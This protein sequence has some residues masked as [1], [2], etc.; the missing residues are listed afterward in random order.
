MGAL[1]GMLRLV[2]AAVVATTMFAAPT[3]AAPARVDTV[4][5]LTIALESLRAGDDAGYEAAADE[6]RSDGHWLPSAGWDALEQRDD[7]QLS[8]V[9]LL[10]DAPGDEPLLFA[11]DQVVVERELNAAPSAGAADL[12]FLRLVDADGAMI[13]EVLDHRGIGISPEART[14]LEPLPSDLTL[15]PAPELY[16]QVVAMMAN[17]IES[18]GYPLPPVPGLEEL[19]ASFPVDQLPPPP[20][21]GPRPLPEPPTAADPPAIET[22]SAEPAAP[23]LA[24]ADNDNDAGTDIDAGSTTETDTGPVTG[25]EAGPGGEGVAIDEAT[26]GDAAIVTEPSIPDAADPGGASNNDVEPLTLVIGAVGA[27]GLALAVVAMRRNRHNHQLADIAYTDS[28]TGLGNRR[29]LDLDLSDEVRHG[30]RPTSVLMIDVD[31]FKRFNDRHGHVAGDDVLRRVATVIARNVRSRDLTYRYGGEEF[32]VLLPDTAPDEA[33]E[34]GER[35]RRAIERARIELADGSDVSV[36]ASL[37]LSSG[38]AH[39]LGH[40]VQRADQA[41]YV[42]KDNGRN[43]LARG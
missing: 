3:H 38:P 31:H 28:L 36:T 24:D 37:G 8:L 11:F 25:G 13:L 27:L 5:V 14:V 18:L 42:A 39:N 15:A 2:A 12:A 22:P 6:L 26:P 19:I 4:D 35:V 40:L 23:A 1:G 16:D 30:A 43:Q 32:S 17:R 34:V 9:W 41:L 21:G 7:E 20:A 29:R 10:L 33:N